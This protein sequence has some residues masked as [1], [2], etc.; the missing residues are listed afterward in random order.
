LC[1]PLGVAAQPNVEVDYFASQRRAM[2]DEQIRGR[3]IEEPRLLNALETVPRHEFVPEGLR[4]EAYRD[5]PLQIGSGQTVSQPYLVALMADLLELDGD[6]KLLEIGTGSGYTTAVLARL[7]HRV[8][9]IEII[10]DLAERA[11]IVLGE[12]GYGNVEVRVGD[13]YRGW[14]E[15]APFDGILLSAAPSEVPPPL[16]EQ[17]KVNGVLVAPVGRTLQDLVVIRKTADG[18]VRRQVDVVRLV[19]MV[20]R[21]QEDPEGENPNF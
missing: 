17:L 3:G 10:D 6:E 13:G 5:E 11:R 14:P 9:S 4:D 12:L 19:P 18:L 16:L 8:Y 7:A 21:A 20:G 2:V 1:A 15:E